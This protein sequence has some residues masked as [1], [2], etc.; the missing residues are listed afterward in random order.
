MLKSFDPRAHLLKIFLFFSKI[1]MKYPKYK[2][3]HF[4]V[5]DAVALSTSTVSYNYHLCLAPERFHLPT[6]KPVPTKLSRPTPLSS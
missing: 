1:K 6:G 2:I 3:N 4:K 5:N